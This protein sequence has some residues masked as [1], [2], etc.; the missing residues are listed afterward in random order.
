MAENVISSNSKPRRLHWPRSRMAI[1]AIAVPVIFVSTYLL[2]W[3]DAY[4]LSSTYLK[5]ANASYQNGRYLD[6]LL[7]YEEFDRAKEEYVDYGG[8]IQVQRIW[9][10]DYA[11]PAPGDAER[12][13]TRIDEIIYSRLTL[14]DA[15]QFVQENIG[16]Y[17]PYM[18]LIYLRLGELYEADGQLFEAQDIYESVPDLFPDDKELIIRAQADLEKLLAQPAD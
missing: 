1:L 11:Y 8:Y 18:G 4:R 6:A 16:R 15:E 10:N 17:N 12:A 3:W 9:E 14:E 5:D 13:E 7:G 2:A